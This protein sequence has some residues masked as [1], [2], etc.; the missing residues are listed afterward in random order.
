MMTKKEILLTLLAALI[1]ITLAG[2]F[3]LYAQEMKFVHW[4]QVGKLEQT[5]TIRHLNNR[6]D[7][8]ERQRDYRS[9]LCTEVLRDQGLI[10]MKPK[11]GC[12]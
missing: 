2:T 10:V 11:K 8:L 4:L 3:Y 12:G 1:T 7:D 5:R 6:I 9:D